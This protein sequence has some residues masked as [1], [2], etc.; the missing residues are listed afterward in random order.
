MLSI[1]SQL[2][3]LQ[4]GCYQAIGEGPPMESSAA[5][6]R[7]PMPIRWLAGYRG[8]SADGVLQCPA[9]GEPGSCF[10]VP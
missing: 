1:S 2:L 9:V 5:G 3:V 6:E 8:G 4:V 7:P 10:S